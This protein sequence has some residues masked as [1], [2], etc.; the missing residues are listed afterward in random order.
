MRYDIMTHKQ[1]DIFMNLLLKHGWS[2]CN[3]WHSS[4]LLHFA[5]GELIWEIVNDTQYKNNV[6]TFFAMGKEGVR[7]SCVKDIF[8]VSDHHGNELD[9][10]NS[11]YANWENFV[12]NL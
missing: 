10:Y 7:A 4:D 3:Y 11:S 12:R 8:S 1:M 2:I 5:D 6:L 9:F